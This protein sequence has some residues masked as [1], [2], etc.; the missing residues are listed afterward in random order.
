MRGGCG[1]GSQLCFARLVA[2]TCCASTGAIAVVALSSTS[3]DLSTRVPRPVED[4]RK[5][6]LFPDGFWMVL[7]SCL[8][9]RLGV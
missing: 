1:L 2:P 4:E 6:R 7:V 5:P 8:R 3:L 9:R